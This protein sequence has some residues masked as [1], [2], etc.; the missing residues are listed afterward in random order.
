MKATYPV[1]SCAE[2]MEWESGL[3]GGEEEREWRAMSRAGRAIG[4]A[5]LEDWREAGGPHSGGRVLVLAGKGHNAGDALI[6]AGEMQ[7]RYPGLSVEVVWVMGER[8]LRPLVRR[9]W[10]ELQETGGDRVRVL[11]ARIPAVGDVDGWLEERLGERVW[12]IGLDGILG[13]QFRPPLRPPLEGLLRWLNRRPGIGLRAAIDLPSGLG[14]VA[15]GEP[16]RADFTY[17]PGIAKRPGFAPG[18]GRWTG[19]LRYLDIGFFSGSEPNAG[20]RGVGPAILRRLTALRDPLKHKKGY[21]HVF[22]AGGSRTMP[23]AILMSVMA[24][25]RSGAGLVTAGVPESLVPGFAAR[26]PEAMWFPWPESEQ[27]GG[28]GREGVE[29]FLARCGAATALVVGPGMGA[30]DEARTVAA[31][32]AGRVACPLLLDA[33]ALRPAVVAAAVGR[34]GGNVLVVTPHAGEFARIAGTD[35]G[36]GVEAALMA[37]CRE[38][39]AVAVLKGPPFTRVTDGSALLYVTTGGPVLARGGSGDVLS[40]LL[41]GLLAQEDGDRL[42]TVARGVCWHGAAAD[43][44]AR[45]EG[46]TPVSASRLAAYLGAALDG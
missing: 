46:V 8:A 18:A 44:L 29:P 15:A 35:P 6:A 9:A 13:M 25:V 32:L 11:A 16:F 3:L 38:R 40:G 26:V 7:R 1:L 10:R 12:D 39:G 22:L 27:G 28:L 36:E 4:A 42:E 17:M 30:G 41:G 5:I 21:G 45:S 33:D 14:D 37:Y 43:C 34:P 31:E 19:R 2:A 24:A 20:R 23:G